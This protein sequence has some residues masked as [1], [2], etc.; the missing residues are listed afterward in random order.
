MAAVLGQGK[1]GAQGEG[2]REHLAGAQG[3]PI[4]VSL[5]VMSCDSGSSLASF[6]VCFY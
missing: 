6:P 1:A 2:G 4:P 3:S 5:E